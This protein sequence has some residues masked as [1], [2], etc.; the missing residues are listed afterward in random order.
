MNLRKKLISDRFDIQ[1]QR[2]VQRGR[3]RGGRKPDQDEQNCL[4][5]NI[6]ISSFISCKWNRIVCI[7]KILYSL[8]IQIVK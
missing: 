3:Q 6:S 1:T 5:F 4:N 8:I 2:D 7:F